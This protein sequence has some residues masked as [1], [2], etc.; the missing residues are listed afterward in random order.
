MDPIFTC[1]QCTFATL[2][3]GI[4]DDHIREYH[5][6]RE[7]HGPNI[8]PLLLPDLNSDLCHEPISNEPKQN[9]RP[10]RPRVPDY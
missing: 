2:A 6:V 5:D 10:V 9:N 1:S 7:P 4:F 8:L 3:E